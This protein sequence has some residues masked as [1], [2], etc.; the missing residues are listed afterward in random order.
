MEG[1]GGMVVY[2]MEGRGE[3]QAELVEKHG[4]VSAGWGGG[5]MRQGLEDSTEKLHAEVNRR[6][7]N[8]GVGVIEDELDIGKKVEL[9]NMNRESI[10]N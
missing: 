3:R 9:K 10:R 8:T 1:K 5:K 7:V 6:I 2:G 4:K